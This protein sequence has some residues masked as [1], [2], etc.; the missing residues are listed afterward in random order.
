[1]D[2]RE[3][4]ASTETEEGHEYISPSNVI[5]RPKVQYSD[6]DQKYH[7]SSPKSRH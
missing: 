7:A 5:Q 6:A 1:M 2:G 3:L 4:T